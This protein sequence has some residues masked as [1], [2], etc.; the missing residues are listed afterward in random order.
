MKTMAAALFVLAM[1]SGVALAQP[2]RPTPRPDRPPVPIDLPVLDAPFNTTGAFPS[3]RQSLMLSKDAHHAVQA[4]AAPLEDRGAW[5]TTALIGLELVFTYLPLGEAWLHE[6][7]HRAVMSRRGISSFN[8]VYKLDLFAETIAV[9]RVRDEDL[10]RLKR[11]HPAEQVRL[12]AAGLEGEHDLLRELEK[13]SFFAHAPTSVVTVGW[14]SKLNGTAYLFTCVT[15]EGDRLTDELNAKDGVDVRR[16]DFTG[17]DFTAWVY[18]LHRPGEPYEARGLHPSGVGIDR[19][20]KSTHLTPRELDY[21]RLQAGLSVLNFIDPH[22]LGKRAFGDPSGTQWMGFLRHDLTPFGFA[23]DAHVFLRRGRMR[24]ATVARAY[25]NKEGMGPGVEVEWLR[26]PMSLAGQPITLSP[27]LAVWLQP[28]D[29]L[30][31]STS[32]T[33][34]GLLSLR[35]ELGARRIRPYVEAEAKTAGWVAG[36]PYLGR[37]VSVRVGVSTLAF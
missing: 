26:W 14:L 20:R 35:A 31:H 4:L 6:E 17:L 29:Q 24:L 30:F 1:A 19:Y 36:N 10:V 8:D 32:V 7:Y 27:R 33:P 2:A 23:V 21:L 11:L 18:D 22:L 28:K 9:S 15:S 34:G 13:D 37:N 25:I 3:M 5:G 12:S 16:R